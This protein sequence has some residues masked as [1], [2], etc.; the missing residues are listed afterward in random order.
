[1][2]RVPVGLIPSETGGR[3]CFPDGFLRLYLCP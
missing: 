3:M 1:M 2:I